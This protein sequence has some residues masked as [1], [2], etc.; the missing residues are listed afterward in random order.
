MLTV[1]RQIRDRIKNQL[2][3]FYAGGYPGSLISLKKNF[4][5][6]L[7]HF[8]SGIIVH[9]AK[10]NILWFNNAAEKIT[11]F[12]R[13][14]VIGKDCHTIFPDGLCGGKCS[15]CNGLPY[16]SHKHSIKI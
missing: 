14:E 13:S 5:T 12:E 3:E 2:E 11:G 16:L 15:F 10:R 1:Y 4:E 9:D 7:D 6:V 8:S